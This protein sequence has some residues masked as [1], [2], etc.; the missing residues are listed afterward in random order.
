MYRIRC[1]KFCKRSEILFSYESDTHP[2]KD[3]RVFIDSQP[4]IVASVRHVL[5]TVDQ[6]TS[7]EKVKLKYVELELMK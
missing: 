4:Y 2:T 5:H 7:T 6:G 3:S 1:V